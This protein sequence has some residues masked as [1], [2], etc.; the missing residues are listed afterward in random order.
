M[1]SVPS[2]ALGSAAA[3]LPGPTFLAILPRHRHV[4]PP[5][6]AVNV[7]C[8]VFMAIQG[9]AG[10]RHMAWEGRLLKSGRRELSTRRSRRPE[11]PPSLLSLPSLPSPKGQTRG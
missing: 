9:E 2:R 5:P 10:H 11:P 1:V 4:L 7:A 3:Q 6:R 8:S